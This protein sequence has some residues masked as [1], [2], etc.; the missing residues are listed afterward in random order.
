MRWMYI[1]DKCYN[2]LDMSLID[3][4]LSLASGLFV[5]PLSL[6]VKSR[7]VLTAGNYRTNG[8]CH[9]KIGREQCKFF[10]DIG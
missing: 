9:T 8:S 2:L 10:F 7:T 5:L 4:I 6:K 1:M 3:F